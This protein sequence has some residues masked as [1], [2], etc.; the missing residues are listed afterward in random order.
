MSE[1]NVPEPIVKLFV[2]T[3][4]PFTFTVIF[5]LIVDDESFKAISSVPTKFNAYVL[6]D[7]EYVP[8]LTLSAHTGAVLSVIIVYVFS[9]LLFPPATSVDVSTNAPDFI[10]I[11]IFPPV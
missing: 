10:V 3:V 11:S 5:P 6:A 2:F 7:A 1:L 8:S 9:A 4:D